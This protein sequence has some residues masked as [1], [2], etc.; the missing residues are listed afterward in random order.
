MKCDR[1]GEEVSDILVYCPH[2]EIFVS[3]PNVRAVIEE[4]NLNALEERYNNA[5]TSANE[6]GFSQSLKDFEEK[7]KKTFSV[8]NIDIDFLHW[9]IFKDY[10]LYSNYTNLVRGK[11]RIPASFKDDSKRRSVQ[12]ILFGGYGENIIYAVLSL[13]GSG[14]KSYGE[15]TIWL[16]EDKIEHRTTLLEENSYHFVIK[17][18]ILPGE[19]IPLGYMSIWKDRHKLAIAKLGHR[20][21]PNISE[22]EYANVLLSSEGNRDTDDF[23]EVHIFGALTNKAIEAVKGRSS[24]VTTDMIAR[25]KAKLG[26]RWIEE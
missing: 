14:L 7:I 26:N 8:I 13:D 24:E 22:K 6:K 23:I 12:D 5:L 17:H 1:C 21:F 2:C 3:Y 19:N 9:F 25:I 18:K 15:Y 11:C 20:I 16:K 10:E 4:G